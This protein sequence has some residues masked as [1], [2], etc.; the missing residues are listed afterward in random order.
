MTALAPMDDKIIIFKQNAIYYIN[1]AGPDNLGSTAV[2]CSLGNYSQPTFITSVVGCTNQQSIVLT[3]RGLMF[4]SDKG[5]WLLGLDLSTEY[6]G[7][8]VEAYNSSTVTSAFVIPQ[9]NFVL[10]T[11]SSGITLMYDYFYGQWGEFINVPAISATLYQGLHTY[12]NK[13]GQV[14]QENPGVYLDGAKPVYRGANAS[15]KSTALSDLALAAN[16]T[17]VAR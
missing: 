14:F 13:F 12:I 6:I 11:L 15:R 17:S 5:I 7:A 1:G 3:P 8:P 10:F 4:Q 2:G 16:Q 9:T